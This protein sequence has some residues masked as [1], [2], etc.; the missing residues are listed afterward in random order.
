MKTLHHPR[1]ILRVNEV[2]K[3]SPDDFIFAESRV[4]LKGRA[5]VSDRAFFICRVDYVIYVFYDLAGLLFRRAQGGFG[6]AAPGHVNHHA[7]ELDRLV[8]LD[9]YRDNISQ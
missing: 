7:S 8:M 1:Q 5:N 9:D 6:L 2:C 3:E 4:A